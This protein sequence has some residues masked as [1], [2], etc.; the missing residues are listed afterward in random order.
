[1][2][3]NSLGD[4]GYKEKQRIIPLF[5][6]GVFYYVFNFIVAAVMSAIEKKLEYFK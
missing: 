5:V 2:V 6:A 4:K 1:M 3:L